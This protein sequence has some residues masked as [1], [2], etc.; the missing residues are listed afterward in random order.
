MWEFST[1][2]TEFPRPFWL[3]IWKHVKIHN[4]PTFILSRELLFLT[5][6][7]EKQMASVYPNWRKREA[8]PQS[9][10][11]ACFCF[12]LLDTLLRTSP[13]PMPRYHAKL[14]TLKMMD[15][16]LGHG[17][18]VRTWV[19]SPEQILLKNPSTLGRQTT[20]W[21]P[22]QRETLPQ[23]KSWWHLRTHPRLPSGLHMR[24]HTYV[25]LH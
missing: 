6:N 11:P 3:K 12:D 5:K 20:W 22:G 4:K 10:E 14:L 23:I 9:P 16:G 17:S 19:P 25:L 15:R 1:H 13:N 18:V 7:N 8:G 21:I 24:V 2:R